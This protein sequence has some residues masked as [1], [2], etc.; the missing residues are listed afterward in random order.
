MP[1]PHFDEAAAHWD[2]PQRVA[3][4]QAVAAEIAKDLPE[5]AFAKVL[6]FGCGTGLV[7]F[8]LLDKIGVGLLLDTSEGM[9]DAVREKIEA[10]GTG[11][12]RA[13]RADITRTEGL[14]QGY[15]LVYTS[16][17]LHHVPDLTPV[18][19]AFHGLLAK[20]GYLCAVDLHADDGGFHKDDPAFDGH[21][22]FE[23]EALA[24][25]LEAAG[26]SAM[27]H[28]TIYQGSKTVDGGEHPYRLF[29]LRAQA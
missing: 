6:E 25:E 11:K 3:R 4:A 21:H 28:R 5:S 19:R 20:D 9:I 13:L 24:R 16:M 18:L 2:T 12:L 22:G 7:T 29:L 8:A 15:S 23:P 14:G 10:T 26:F 1:K 27:G 17:A